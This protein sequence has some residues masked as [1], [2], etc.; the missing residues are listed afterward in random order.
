MHRVTDSMSKRFLIVLSLASFQW[1]CQTGAE[2]VGAKTASPTGEA[3]IVTLASP[4]PLINFKIMVRVGSTAD[5]VGKEGLAELTASGLVEGGFGDPASPVKKDELAKITLPWGRGAMPYAHVGPETTTFH[6]TVPR[7]AL[8]EYTAKVLRPMFASPLFL[9]GDVERLKKEQKAQVTSYRSEDLENLGLAAI[10][11]MVNRGSRYVH[12]AFGSESSIPNLSTQDAKSFF[13]RH[14]RRA[15]VILGVSTDDA[16]TV[17]L[18]R[19]VV[20]EL[21]EGQSD[22]TPALAATPAMGRHAFVVEEPNAPAAS[23]HVGFPL[24]VARGHED[25]WPLY[26]ASV[27]LGTHRDSFGRLYRAIRQERGYN[28]GNYSYIEHWDG[29][30]RSLFQIFNQPRSRQYFSMWVRP[31]GYE[32]AQHTL[33]AAMW[34]LDRL[35]REGLT[36]EQVI[37][38]KG[39]ARVLYLNLGE[40]VD[41][42]LAAK[43]DDRFL[44][45]SSGFLDDYLK[46]IDAVTLEQVNAAIKRHLCSKNA[47]VLIVTNKDNAAKLAE[48]LKATDAVYGKG[49]ADYE[50]PKAKLED[51]REAWSVPVDKVD[52]I[53]LDAVWAHYPLELESVKHITVDE[54]FKTGEFSAK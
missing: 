13:G 12:R 40:T 19:S 18:L 37:A 24:D 39:K 50:F 49:L 43:M 48:D 2:T 11:G 42:L 1:S 15:S 53:R 38:A 26:V 30:P 33:K 23:V 5:P 54:L 41:R 28:Y 47:R 52:M 36:E 31:V 46:S 3:E 51:G 7:D 32:H 20:E 14:Y 25:F 22:A 8:D 21:P 17:G 9:E 35:H 45:L 27:W 44:G 34:E 16:E 6:F 29:R 10:D 4:S